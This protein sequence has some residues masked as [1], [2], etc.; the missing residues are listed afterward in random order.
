MINSLKNF[1]ITNI[2]TGVMTNEQR[3]KDLEGNIDWEAFDIMRNKV[4]I[5]I[6]HEKDMVSIKMMTDPKSEGGE[7][8][9]FTDFIYMSKLMCE[10]L[11]NKFPCKANEETLK[12]LKDALAH[13]EQR[14]SDRRGRGVE[15]KDTL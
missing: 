8:A 14:T 12:C 13:Q 1:E 6:D 2:G 4:P 5:C 3:P 10:Y 15:G 11:H 7:G 9:Q